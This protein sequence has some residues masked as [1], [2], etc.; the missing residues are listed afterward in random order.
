MCG[1][2]GACKVGAWGAGLQTA[3]L[4]EGLVSWT[5]GTQAVMK[6]EAWPAVVGLKTLGFDPKKKTTINNNENN[7]SN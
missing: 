3:W 1:E 2:P 5:L 4:H 6:R 7:I